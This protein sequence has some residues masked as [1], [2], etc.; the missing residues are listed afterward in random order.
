[1]SALKKSAY[2]IVF[3]AVWGGLEMSLGAVL[4]AV[5]IP[6]RGMM[7]ASVGAFMLCSAQLWI[8]GRWTCLSVGGITAFLKLFSIG[9]LVLSPAVAILMESLLA[10]LVFL[11]LKRNLLGCLISGMTVV[12]FTIIHK[13]FSMTI[14]YK[15][16]FS[17]IIDTFLKQGNFISEMGVKSLLIFFSIYLAIHLIFGILAGGLA[18]FTVGRTSV[19]LGKQGSDNLA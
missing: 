2:I 15:S 3:V 10:S 14:V 8:G 11:G 12:S 5:H 1:M 6:L 16:E 19:I 18:Y 17:D 4:H 9:G 13:V 7:L